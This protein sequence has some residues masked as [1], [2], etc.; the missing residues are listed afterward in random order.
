MPDERAPEAP[1]HAE[2][3][4]L[5]LRSLASWEKALGPDHPYVGM[6]YRERARL[7]GEQG[8]D[9]E[10]AAL[11]ARAL[12]LFEKRQEKNDEIETLEYY[13]PLLKRMGRT[14]EALPLE[15]RLKALR[16]GSAGKGQDAGSQ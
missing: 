11:Y 16:N 10:A 15:N 7:Y 13:V 14:G 3:E 9:A 6:S 4:P 1:S 2:A 12:R 8:R 5:Y